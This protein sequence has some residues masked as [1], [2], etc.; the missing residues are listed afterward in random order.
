VVLRKS[1]SDNPLVSGQGV[2]T[3]GFSTK[4]ED[5]ES[6]LLYY[7]YRYYDAVTGRWLSRDPIEEDGGVNLYCANLNNSIQFYD[8]LGLKALKTLYADVQGNYG[9]AP[10]QAA[11]AALK[12]IGAKGMAPGAKEMGGLILS[13]VKDGKRVALYTPAVT[14]PSANSI[15]LNEEIKKYKNYRG[16][17]IYGFYHTHPPLTKPVN[18]PI[19]RPGTTDLVW[20]EYN[21]NMHRILFFSAEDVRYARANEMMA[22]YMASHDGNIKMV[23][24][25]PKVKILPLELPGGIVVHFNSAPTIGRWK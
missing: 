6:G 21:L 16:F 4:P 3:Y 19:V 24:T 18:P 9:S 14:S 12:D 20:R 1:F 13:C 8:V 5:K 17:S 7:G 23:N 22:A 15:N 11:I 10:N 25:D 2:V